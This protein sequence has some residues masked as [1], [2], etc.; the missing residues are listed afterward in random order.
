MDGRSTAS[1]DEDHEKKNEEDG[2]DAAAVADVAAACDEDIDRSP[3]LP[4]LL[5]KSLKKAKTCCIA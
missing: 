4:S 1:A 5:P 3:F 2:E